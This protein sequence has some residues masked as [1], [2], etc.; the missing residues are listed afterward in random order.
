M[1]EGGGVTAPTLI[2]KGLLALPVPTA[3][4]PATVNEVCVCTI[5][6]QVLPLTLSQPAP[7]HL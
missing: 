1:L 5:T 2:T 7:V 4:I 6:V 3:L